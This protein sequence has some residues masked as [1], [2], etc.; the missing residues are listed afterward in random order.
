MEEGEL[1]VP[2]AGH[3]G[4]GGDERHADHAAA[5]VVLRPADHDLLA[6]LPGGSGT[7]GRVVHVAR[8]PQD[9]RARVGA[10]LTSARLGLED[11]V[12]GVRLGHVGMCRG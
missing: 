1:G 7:V 11:P 8:I 9:V 5:V 2:R 10:L 4:V 6:A 12:E 3:H